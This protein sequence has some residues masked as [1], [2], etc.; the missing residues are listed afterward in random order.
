MHIHTCTPGTINY[1]VAICS[2]VD[3]STHTH[4]HTLTHTFHPI[5]LQLRLCIDDYKRA[6]R[7][8]HEII[9]TLKEN[10]SSLLE[11]IAALTLRNSQLDKALKQSKQQLSLRE[12]REDTEFLKQQVRGRSLFPSNR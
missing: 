11:E 9:A 4:T 3:N 6:E 7:E 5:V 10:K 8:S 2:H 12:P 1:G